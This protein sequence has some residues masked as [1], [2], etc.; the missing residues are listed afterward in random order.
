MVIGPAIGS[1]LI[2]TY[3]I[4]TMLNGE[5][6]SHPHTGHLLRCR[7]DQLINPAAITAHSQTNQVDI[8][9][10]FSYLR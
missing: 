3:G 6:R 10:C 4:P 9:G 2:R 7:S 1:F 5:A 8:G